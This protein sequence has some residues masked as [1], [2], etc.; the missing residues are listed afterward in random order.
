MEAA[1]VELL[2]A[3]THLGTVGVSESLRSVPAM[4]APARSLRRIVR[5]NPP[6]A[7][8]LIGNDIFNVLLGR[9]CRS[10]GIP[11]L[12]YFP[13]QVWIWRSLAWLFSRSFDQVAASFPE[14]V[15]AYS[16]YVR[17]EYVGHYL[18][19]VLE[20]QTD[21]SRTAARRRMDI[22]DGTRVVTVLPGSRAQEI[23][24]LFGRM[25]G[26]TAKVAR[27]RSDTTFLLPIS[28]RTFEDVI[29]EGVARVGLSDRV[30]IVTDSHDAM[31]ASDLV[32]AA[33]GTATLEAT[34]IGVPMVVVYRISAL[35]YGVVRSAIFAGLMRG[36]TMALPNLLLGRHVVPELSQS[37]VTEESISSEALSLLGDEVRCRQ[38]R[39]ALHAARETISR[40]G[41]IDHVV[42]LVQALADRR[43]VQVPASVTLPAVA[44][45]TRGQS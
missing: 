40:P 30:R 38:M 4:I 32:I 35:T 13:P 2:A 19:D 22:P 3:A 1:G 9:W 25:I 29:A 24:G 42:A 12:S 8:V 20:P 45:S 17:T 18:A 39:D 16:K 33:S 21:G 27:E 6:E 5:E 31:R 14:E 34:L 23:N 36:E 37:R 15:E 44:G 41:T 11:T 26:A 43:S 28:D 10:A 7:A